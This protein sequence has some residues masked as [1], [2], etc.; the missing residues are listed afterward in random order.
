M[1]E[2]SPACPYP[3]TAVR[4]GRQYLR[5]AA[6]WELAVHEIIQTNIDR[7]KEL[8]K[9]E[10]APTKRAMVSRLLTKEEVELK[11]LPKPK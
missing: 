7:F 10:T 5:I 3:A 8:L 6:G 4:S 2:G 11:Q 1:I 9:T